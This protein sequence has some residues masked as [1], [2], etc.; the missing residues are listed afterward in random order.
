MKGGVMTQYVKVDVDTNNE[1]LDAVEVKVRG[2][3]SVHVLV[4]GETVD[5]MVRPSAP[6]VAKVVH[7]GF[8][9]AINTPLRNRSLF[10]WLRKEGQKRAQRRIP[11]AKRHLPQTV[12]VEGPV[13]LE[14]SLVFRIKTTCW[15]LKGVHA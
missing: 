2:K 7:I 5:V 4:P 3:T 13:D 8:E 10:E 11:R 6:A 9:E 15:G 1:E 12:D 14:G